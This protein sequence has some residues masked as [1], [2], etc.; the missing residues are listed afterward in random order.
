LPGGIE[1]FLPRPFSISVKLDGPARRKR[2]RHRITVGRLTPMCF[3]IR[4]LESPSA[5]IKIIRHR[6]TTLCGVFWARTQTLSVRWWSGVIKS[7]LADFHIAATIHLNQVIVKL[8]VRQYTRSRV[9]LHLIYYE[10]CLNER[11]AFRREKYLK[12]TY[13]KRFI[14][15]R[16]RSYFTGQ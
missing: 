7:F 13:G 16:C 3:A 5:A 9:P 6:V 1:G 2:S 8:F 14:K 12:T 15:T 11:D 10:A 4:L